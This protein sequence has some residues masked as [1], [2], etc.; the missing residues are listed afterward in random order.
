[1]SSQH[2]TPVMLVVVDLNCHHDMMVSFYPMIG[3]SLERQG[4][5]GDNIEHLMER[6]VSLTLVRVSV[7]RG[8]ILIT[9]RNFFVP[10][11]QIQGIKATRRLYKGVRV[12][13]VVAPRQLRN[14]SRRHPP[15]IIPVP[16]RRREM[17]LPR[18]QRRHHHPQQQS[19]HRKLIH[20]P[21][22]MMSVLCY[23]LIF[24]QTRRQ[25]H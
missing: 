10:N 14:S 9:R 2:Q 6:L 3:T 17:L 15:N 25:Q 12:M 16:Q 8:V 5:G 22:C 4:G 1:M 11:W 13:L 23:H 19:L 21:S 18:V 24:S 7:Q 20:I